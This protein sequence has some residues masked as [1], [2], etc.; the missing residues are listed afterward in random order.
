MSHVKGKERKQMIL[1]PSSVDEYVDKNNPVRVID[2][3]VD[4]LDLKA[5]GFD[6][7]VPAQTG[8]PAYAP[9]DLLKL[10]I[11][12]YMNKIR[13][14]RKLM[15]ECRRNIEL[16]VLLN[17]L[18]PDFRTISDFRKNSSI[19]LRHSVISFLLDRILFM[20]P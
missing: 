16:F 12:G 2:A 5:L 15:T 18:K 19:F 9:A 1:L 13:S 7:A 6:K 14:S 11:Y 17:E 3:F 10:Y 8:R 20:Y 4:I